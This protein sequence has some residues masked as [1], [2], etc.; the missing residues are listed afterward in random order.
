MAVSS[1]RPSGDGQ[2]IDALIVG[3]GFA[4]MYMLHKLRG[5]GFNAKGVEAG[6]GVGG[7]WYWNRYPGARVDIQSLEYSFGFDEDLEKEWRW[8]E[9]YA[10]QPELLNYAEHVADRFDLKRDIRFNTRVTA[11]HWDEAAQV[12]KVATDPGEALRCRHLILATGC[13]SVPTDV[14]FPG[15]DTFQGDIYRTSRWPHEGVDFSGRR[16]GI[17]G[18]GSSAIQSIP[19]IAEQ[20]EHLTVFQRT[21]NYSMPAHNGPIPEA[22][23]EAWAKD[24]RAY[25]AASRDTVGGFQNEA[26]EAMAT[27]TAPE[28]V[29]AELERRWAW[30]GFRILGAFADTAVDPDANRIVQDFIAEK[31][32][33]QVADPAVADL[34]TP[35]DH[36]FG[37]KRPCV[38]TG[39]YATFNRPNVELVNLRAEPLV[40][41]NAQGIETSKKAYAFDAVVLATG[42]D[43]MTGAIDRIDLR[44]VGGRRIKDHWAEGPRTYLGLMV[45][46][47]PN[48]FTITGPGSP[49]VLTNM[50]NSIEQHVDWIADCLVALKQRQQT[51]IEASPEAEA[52][53]CRHSTEA[54]TPTML[55]QANSWYMGANVPGKPRM[56]MPYAGGLNTYTE[57]CNQV[58]AKGYEGFIIRQGDRVLSESRD[59]TSQPAP[60]EIPENLLPIIVE[61][62]MAAGLMPDAT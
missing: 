61:R 33:G 25:R 58:A 52:A 53:W 6:S 16:V 35:K 29:R 48:M 4:G 54:V 45:A 59:F 51:S 32:R 12:W 47:F 2:L 15:L 30:G 14:T 31:I 55:P 37:T 7:T 28:E 19:I 62:L 41:F 50:I 46:G 3:A 56:F 49:S 36:P 24:P 5:L 60:G 23:L 43:A 38:D 22:E 11:A 18:T 26:S 8:S 10:P 57:I 39:Y 44:G 17:I 13:L 40:G 9:R 21:P 34:L 27:L 1:E 20:A 42:F